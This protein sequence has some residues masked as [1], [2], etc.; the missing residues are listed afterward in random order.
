MPALDDSARRHLERRLVFAATPNGAKLRGQNREAA[1]RQLIDASRQ[2]PSPEIPAVAQGVWINRALRY[3]DTTASQLTALNNEVARENLAAAEQLRQAWLEEMIASPAPLRENIVLFLHSTFGGSVRT[4]DG[5]Q[6]LQGYLSTL[7][8]HAFGTV[9]DLL[10]ALILDPGMM[11]QEGH[12]ESRKELPSDYSAR[13]VLNKWTVGEGAY[14]DDDADGL[15]RSLTG[16]ILE[17]APGA[18]PTRTL[19]PRGFRANR[20]TGLVPTFHANFFDDAPKTILGTTQNFGARD[21]V[22][23]LALQDATAKRYARLLIRYFGVEDPAGNLQARLARTYRDTNGSL[24]F[25][26]QDLALSEEFWSAESRWMLIK[27]PV[28]LGVG[29]AR[30]LDLG[31]ESARAISQWLGPAGQRLLEAPNLGAQGWPGQRAWLDPADRLV[32]RYDLADAIFGEE[33]LRRSS[34]DWFTQLDPAPGL[35]RARAIRDVVATP[36]YQIA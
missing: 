10:E 7:R 22:R 3:P 18:G 32:A 5:P 26:L 36:Q 30:Q 20:R 9:P 8:R 21:A 29:F 24:E 15:A 13:Q 12:D 14:S 1:V 34:R 27:S 28:Q 33:N 23:F 16:W 31:R 17:A 11:M 2:A 25:L 35:T 19:D 4:I 6:A